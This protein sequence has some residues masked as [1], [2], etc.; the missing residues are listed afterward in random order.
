MRG[1][2]PNF[3]RVLNILA[4]WVGVFWIAGGVV[5]LVSSFV[6]ATDR[7]VYAV[8]GLFALAAGLGFV[9]VKPIRQRDFVRLKGSLG[10]EK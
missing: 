4:R 2:E 7:V 8:A 5:F 6:S 3:S 9:L 1:R 10:S